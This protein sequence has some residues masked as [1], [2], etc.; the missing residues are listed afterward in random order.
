MGGKGIVIG[1][2]C[3][4]SVYER[5]VVEVRRPLKEHVDADGGMVCRVVIAEGVPAPQLL[6]A[7]DIVQKTCQPA[8]IDTHRGK[9]RPLRDA[10][11]ELGHAQGVLDLERNARV[12]RIVRSHVGVEGRARPARG[13]LRPGPRPPPRCVSSDHLKAC[14]KRNPAGARRSARCRTH[15]S[16]LLYRFCSPPRRAAARK[17]RAGAPWRLRAGAGRAMRPVSPAWC[18][19]RRGCRAGSR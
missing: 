16:R 12:I 1:P 19:R 7:P 18:P 15:A 13:R 3:G 11:G 4:Y 8:D 6:K 14:L 2:R 9:A 5:R 17:A 10:L